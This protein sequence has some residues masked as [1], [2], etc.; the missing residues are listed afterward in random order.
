MGQTSK[1]KPQTMSPQ[2]VYIPPGIPWKMNQRVYTIQAKKVE[3]ISTILRPFRR[4][5]YLDSSHTVSQQPVNI[6]QAIPSPLHKPYTTQTQPVSQHPVTT[7]Q[8]IMSP[9]HK[10]YTAQRAIPTKVRPDVNHLREEDESAPCVRDPARAN[11]QVQQ[12][13]A[14]KLH[15]LTSPSS[16]RNIIIG[17]SLRLHNLEQ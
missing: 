16:R 9:L 15:F 11:P 13:N 6:P 2:G 1:H 7:T 5:M 8:A 17:H 14:Y 4:H 10:P 3:A 12:Q